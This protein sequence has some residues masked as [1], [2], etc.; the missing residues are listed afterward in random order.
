MHTV[1][2]MANSDHL[3]G[4]SGRGTGVLK[5][6]LETKRIIYQF[7]MTYY[8]DHLRTCRG[9]S[10]YKFLGQLKPNPSMKELLCK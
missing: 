10:H 1:Q 3:S 9:P 2:V 5:K 4:A 8:R 6:M 7:R